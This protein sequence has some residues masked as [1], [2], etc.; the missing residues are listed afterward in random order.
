MELLEPVKVP[1][2]QDLAFI[3]L[4]TS[5]KFIYGTFME[6]HYTI[7]LYNVMFV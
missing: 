6:L 1:Y 7:K 5:I 4:E 3:E 2:L